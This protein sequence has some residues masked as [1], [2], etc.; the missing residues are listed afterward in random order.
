MNKYNLDSLKMIFRIILNYNYTD[1]S[2]IPFHVKGNSKIV[3]GA[4]NID[5]KNTEVFN[6]WGNIWNRIIRPNILTK[7]LNFL[8]ERVLNLYLNLHDDYYINKVIN[9]ASF[10]FL[11]IERV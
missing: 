5:N 1:Y 10:S 6:E 7:S 8:N 2:G 4:Q 9:K 11:V 3:Y